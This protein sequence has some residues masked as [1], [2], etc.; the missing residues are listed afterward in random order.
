MFIFL[1]AGHE[2]ELFPSSCRVAL[3]QFPTDHSAYA[4]LLIC[5]IGSS[6]RRAGATVSKHQRCYVQP[7]W[8]ARGCEESQ[9]VQIANIPLDL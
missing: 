3:I 9:F 1:L 7:G 5:V 8:N 2:V 4:M 6:S